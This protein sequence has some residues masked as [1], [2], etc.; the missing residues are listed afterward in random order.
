MTFALRL[1]GAEV[2]TPSGLTD[3]PL[4]IADGL[5]TDDTPSREVDLTDYLILPGLVDAHGDAF[6]KHLAPGAAR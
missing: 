5:I 3:M 6:E 1:T 4:A 2:L